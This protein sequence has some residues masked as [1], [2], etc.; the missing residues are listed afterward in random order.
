MKYLLIIL[1][2]SILTISCKKETNNK[3]EPYFKLKVNGNKTSLGSC[4]FFGGGG[5]EFSCSISGDSILFITVG[6]DTKLGFLIRGGISDGTY[7]LDNKNQ[8]WYEDNNLK[9]FR[10][11]IN[12][13]G[14]LTIVKGT[15]QS[16]GVIQTLKGNFSFNAIDTLSGQLINITDGE[17]LMERREY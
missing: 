4:G 8:S 7:Q 3:F 9:K 17:F 6:C 10:T 15:F 11:T 16:A 14:N 2:I 1:T 5:G 13:K 12:Q